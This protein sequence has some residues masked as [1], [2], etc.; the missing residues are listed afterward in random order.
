M[1]YVQLSNEPGFFPYYLG[2]S[3]PI[4][5]CAEDA[6]WYNTDIEAR[7]AMELY[8]RSQPP[9]WPNAKVLYDDRISLIKGKDG[10]IRVRISE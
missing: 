6:E 9:I 4:A 1:W 2:H 7:A 5:V 3:K 8:C 10:V